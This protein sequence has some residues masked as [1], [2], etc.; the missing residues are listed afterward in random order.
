MDDY[1]GVKSLWLESNRIESIQ[2]LSNQT[3]LRGLYL[4]N[5]QIKS[6]Q[7]LDSLKLLDTINLSHNYIKKLENLSCCP[8]LTSLIITH[9]ELENAAGL[10]HLIDCVN[11][12]CVDLSF[13]NINDPEVIHVFKQMKNL[14]SVVNFLTF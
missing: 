8:L 12:S 2:N 13:N 4:H 3:L 10:E 5:N 6:I 14:V 11:L 1:T 7:N 9:N